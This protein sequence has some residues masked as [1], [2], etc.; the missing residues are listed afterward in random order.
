[1]PAVCRSSPP[2]PLSYRETRVLLGHTTWKPYRQ[3]VQWEEKPEDKLVDKLTDQNDTAESY[4]RQQKVKSTIP[5]KL[6]YGTTGTL[7]KAHILVF[8]LV[9]LKL[10]QFQFVTDSF[11]VF[12]HS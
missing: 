9:E 6:A 8:H 3:A 5:E 10:C 1:L 2:N 4:N 11:S 12:R 7:N